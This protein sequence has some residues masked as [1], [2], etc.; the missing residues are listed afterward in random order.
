MRPTKRKAA[1]LER[2]LSQAEALFWQF[3]EDNET[4]GKLPISLMPRSGAHSC[5]K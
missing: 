4:D 1:I 2:A 5:K 3:L